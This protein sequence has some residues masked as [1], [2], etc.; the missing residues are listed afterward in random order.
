[1]NHPDSVLKLVENGFREIAILGEKMG[2]I[3][4]LMLWSLQRMKRSILKARLYSKRSI[5]RMKSSL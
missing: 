2:Q 1:M 3:Q 5:L 4:I